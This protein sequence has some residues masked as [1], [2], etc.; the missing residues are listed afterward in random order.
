MRYEKQKDETKAIN[1]EL[2]V[3]VDLKPFGE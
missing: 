1:D 3:E 2:K